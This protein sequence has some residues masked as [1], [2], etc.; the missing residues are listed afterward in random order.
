MRVV[1]FCGSR[2]GDGAV[3]NKPGVGVLGNMD[4][5]A[6]ATD[7]TLLAAGCGGSGPDMTPGGGP[8][9]TR[10]LEA[11]IAAAAAATAAEPPCRSCP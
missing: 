8:D 11:T 6:A 1:G 7:A 3:G 2:L 9:G 10:L 5:V 4:K